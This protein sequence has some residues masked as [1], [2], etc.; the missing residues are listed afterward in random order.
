[1]IIGRMINSTGQH[2]RYRKTNTL[3]SKVYFFFLK[4]AIGFPLKWFLCI[5]SSEE[6]NKPTYNHSFSTE[7]YGILKNIRC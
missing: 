7:W 5:W 1:M 4:K 6:G 2:E 3:N